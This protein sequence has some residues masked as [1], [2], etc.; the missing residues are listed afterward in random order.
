MP[1]T[2][3]KIEA[4]AVALKKQI[5][6]VKLAARLIRISILRPAGVPLTGAQSRPL[7]LVFYRTGLIRGQTV[8][9][10]P[11]QFAHPR[12]SYGNGQTQLPEKEV[13]RLETVELRGRTTFRNS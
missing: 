9:S 2:E 10:L 1:R 11:R 5:T 13:S 12:M 7:V 4:N 8:S 3:P 6:P